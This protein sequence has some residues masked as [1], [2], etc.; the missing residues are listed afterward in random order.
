M[1]YFHPL[2]QLHSPFSLKSSYE[3]DLKLSIQE[4]IGTPAF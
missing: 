4:A 1:S 2:H 3:K